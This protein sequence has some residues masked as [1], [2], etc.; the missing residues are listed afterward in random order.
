MHNNGHCKRSEEG[1]E[2]FDFV[3]ACENIVTAWEYITPQ[4][5]EKCCHHAGFIISVPIAPEQETEPE[6]NIWDNMQQILNVKVPFSENSIADDQVETTERL[7][8]AQIVE[9]IKN[10]HEIQEQED[11]GPDPD[12]DDHDDDD[13]S[14]TGSVAESTTAADESEIIH[15]ANQ[16]LQLLAKHRAYVL[17]NKLTS[18][19]TVALNTVEQILL[20]SKITT[21]RKTNKH[22]VI[23]Q[24]LKCLPC[25]IKIYTCTENQ[26]FV[27]LTDNWLANLAEC[28]YFSVLYITVQRDIYSSS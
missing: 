28:I 6:R 9:K 21:C 22:L 19:A 8:D 20:D 27:L 23:F 1:N 7:N 18:S 16:F 17:R 13:I 24:P 4:L 10:C 3:T 11:V 5:I 15:T 14:T 2:G 12:K 25:S 26:I